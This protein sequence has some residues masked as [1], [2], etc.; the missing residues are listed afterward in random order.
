MVR[1]YLFI[2][3]TFN[4]LLIYGME[5]WIKKP[6]AKPQKLAMPIICKSIKF[7]IKMHI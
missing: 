5:I 6:L 7:R 1:V 2:I 3:D 4:S